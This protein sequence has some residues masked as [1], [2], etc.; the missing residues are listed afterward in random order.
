MK[1]ENVQKYKKND[2]LSEEI[3]TRGSSCDENVV[4]LEAS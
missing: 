1:E 4:V 3:T 2:T